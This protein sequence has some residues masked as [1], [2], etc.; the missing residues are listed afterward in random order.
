MVYVHAICCSLGMLKLGYDQVAEVPGYPSWFVVI[1]PD[2]LWSMHV[3]LEST[4]GDYKFMQVISEHCESS[5][6]LCISCLWHQF[7][8]CLKSE[9]HS[10]CIIWTFDSYDLQFTLKN[11]VTLYLCHRIEMTSIHMYLN[12]FCISDH[13]YIFIKCERCLL[14]T[15]RCV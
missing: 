8:D 10:E 7:C 12:M 3:T 11:L 6:P 9:F 2:L 1:S 13:D 14:Y 15:S 4:T 5:E